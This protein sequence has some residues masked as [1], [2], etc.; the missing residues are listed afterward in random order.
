MPLSSQRVSLSVEFLM[1]FSSPNGILIIRKVHQ[2][3]FYIKY[4]SCS[5]FPI[6]MF[7]SYYR[8]FYTPLRL[9]A[10]PTGIPTVL[11]YSVC[12]QLNPSSCSPNLFPPWKESC[13]PEAW[14]PSLIL[15]SAWH[16]QTPAKSCQFSFLNTPQICPLPLIYSPLRLSG[17]RHHHFFPGLPCDPRLTHVGFPYPRQ[18]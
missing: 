7:Y 4:I 2:V 6:P 5:P 1:L 11:S 12:L 13:K 10:S 14:V 9:L 16:T 15:C 3:F 8:H 18:I 17:P